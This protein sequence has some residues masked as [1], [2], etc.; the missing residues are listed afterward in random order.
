LSWDLKEAQR[1]FSPWGG[2]SLEG[3][4]RSN[5]FI[6]LSLQLMQATFAITRVEPKTLAF[7]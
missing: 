4:S 2:D 7:F 3:G 6:I 1:A 5:A